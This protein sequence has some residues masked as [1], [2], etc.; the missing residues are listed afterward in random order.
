M[1]FN[2]LAVQVPSEYPSTLLKLALAT[3]YANP[4]RASGVLSDITKGVFP[5][6][7]AATAMCPVFD[8]SF[9]DLA[10]VGLVIVPTHRL[11]EHLQLRDNVVKIFRLN[12]LLTPTLRTYQTNRIALAMGIEG[13][14][15]EVL[16]SWRALMEGINSTFFPYLSAML[17][18][19][20][21]Q[22]NQIANDVR[23]ANAVPSRFAA[24]EKRLQQLIRRRKS[25]DY[26]ALEDIQRLRAANPLIFYGTL[27]GVVFVAVALVQVQVFLYGIMRIARDAVSPAAAV[28]G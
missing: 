6:L 7:P 18:L 25:W 5:L 17:D 27:M 8:V 19:S 1:P 14:G 12:P 23:F 26:I 3:P 16:G 4:Y 10:A 13:I 28:V 2:L 24:R 9:S 21:Q 11:D 22:L 15:K 20:T